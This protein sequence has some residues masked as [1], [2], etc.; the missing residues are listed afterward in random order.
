VFVDCDRE[1][2][3]IDVAEV[4]G[5]ITP[6]TA[7]IIGVHIFGNPAPAVELEKISRQ[8]NIPLFFDAAHGFGSILNG[9]KIG[10]FGTAESF[11]LSPTKLLTTAEGGIVATNSDQLAVEIRK[12]RNYGDS[13]D[14]DCAWPGFNAR[15][16]ELHAVLGL[17]SLKYL[18]QNVRRRNRLAEIYKK[19][20]GQIPGVG[21]QKIDE[22]NRSSLKDFSIIL[23]ESKFGLT[24]DQLAS[25]LAAENIVVKKYFYPPV[26]WQKAY[27]DNASAKQN[28]F[29]NTDYVTTH[30]LSLPLFSH[31]DEKDVQEIIRAVERIYEDRSQI[32]IK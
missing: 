23:D 19:K 31:M 26:H 18:E 20:L 30:C 27:K 32:G 3:T 29:E 25:A 1:K 12:G 21:F 4:E 14:Y 17:H 2:F 11:S 16:S 13:G 10:S 22:G 8:K 28:R 5:A 9:R 24:R 7:A 6:Q 15:M